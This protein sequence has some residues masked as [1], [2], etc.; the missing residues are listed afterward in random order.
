MTAI[1]FKLGCRLDTK[2]HP[3]GTLFD[4]F[5]ITSGTGSNSGFMT[6]AATA[7]IDPTTTEYD[8]MFVILRHQNTALT[9]KKCKAQCTQVIVVGSAQGAIDAVLC[10]ICEP[11]YIGVWR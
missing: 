11:E 3:I 4:T 7:K 1:S 10:V 9:C 8:D 2:Y 5:Q 6:I